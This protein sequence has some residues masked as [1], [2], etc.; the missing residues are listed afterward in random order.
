MGIAWGEKEQPKS[1][2]RAATTHPDHPGDPMDPAYAGRRGVT[3]A[4]F[5]SAARAAIGD[6][7]LQGAVKNATAHL[8]SRRSQAIS[9]LEGWEQLRSYAQ[10]VKAYTIAGL[11]R[12]V[13]LF[14]E[15]A[16][17]LGATVFFAADAAEAN[18]YI[19]DL[20]LRSGATLAV[21]SKSMATE[22]VE[23]NEALAEAGVETVETDLGEFVIQLAGERPSH[24]VAPVIHR[25]RQDVTR[26][27]AEKLKTPPDAPVEDLTMTARRVLRERFLRAGLG[28][29]GGNFAIAETGSIVIV[30]N[31]GNARLTTSVPP[32][33]VALVGIEKILPRWADLGAF[34]Q[35]LPRS[36]TG[37]KL[38]SYVSI[39]GGPRRR[40]EP[41]GPSEMHIVLLDNGRTRIAA[42]AEMREVLHCIRC[43]ACLN[44]CPVYRQIG[45]H[46]YGSAYPGPIGSLF[47][48]LI[49][50]VT[51]APDLPFASTLC[52]A[53]VDVCPVKIPIPKLLLR[54]RR[55]V[56]ETD[57]F[58]WADRLQMQAWKFFMSGPRRYA[59]GSRLL[60][61]S[62]PR[63]SQPP[64]RLRWA[65][66]WTKFR[67]Y[68]PLPERS[69]REQWRL[70]PRGQ[71]G[72]SPAEVAAAP[73]IQVRA[74][75]ALQGPAELPD[76][77]LAP[78]QSS[79]RDVDRFVQ[80]AVL[81]GSRVYRCRPE[82]LR[83]TVLKALENLPP[84]CL[85]LFESD[86]L[87][88]RAGWAGSAD[89][90]VRAARVGDLRAG[91]R[92][93]TMDANSADVTAGITGVDAALADT[94]T[95]VL[96][97]SPDRGRLLS[98]LPPVHV[99]VLDAASLLPD[100][101]SFLCQPRVDAS[102]IVLI[103][104]PSKTADIEQNLVTG[105]HGPGELH[106][107]LVLPS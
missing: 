2:L 80:E 60:R 55:R 81:V 54:L 9:Q 44:T 10:Q 8:L 27:F 11:S 5:P 94:G 35:L 52:G 20:A 66:A 23:L 96:R 99:A 33:H 95:L 36:A 62:F 98:L 84:Q 1:G 53:C 67:D 21:K 40:G 22:E 63:E 56:A 61:W 26:L 92:V 57:E 68:P 4:I 45:G 101:G 18:G 88:R 31:E 79:P 25:T 89:Q 14:A 87:A 103:T 46:P 76:P 100:L 49:Q 106:V 69:F 77:G 13:E 85:A 83:P 58:A 51:R 78:R 48:P 64:P 24:I 93:A 12:H 28:I 38:T 82:E 34:L 71:G 15:R 65:A 39:L 19:R 105:V 102:S 7:R 17:A 70:N 50:G 47:T 74:H 3:P 43:G 42:D 59:A 73:G 32:I 16:R 72:G 30:E 104:G 86:S 107:I 75:E 37:Q 91:E 6:A 90:P 97:T 29:S 41:D